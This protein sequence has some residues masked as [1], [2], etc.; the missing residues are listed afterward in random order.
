MSYV[1]I[2]GCTFLSHCI[3]YKQQKIKYGNK[4]FSNTIYIYSNVIYIKK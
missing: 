1:H 3:I 2:E 4:A